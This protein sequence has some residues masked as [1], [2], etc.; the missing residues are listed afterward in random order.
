MAATPEIE[1]SNGAQ[2]MEHRNFQHS[3]STMGDADIKNEILGEKIQGP[4]Y[5]QNPD[6]S[7]DLSE[8][9][10]K[11]VFDV[12]AI[13]PVLS[14][15]MQL[16]NKAIDEIGMTSFQWKM[17]FLNGFGYAV[18]SV[19]PSRRVTTKCVSYVKPI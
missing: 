8:D 19:R 5:T 6:I 14:R 18:D 12:E 1:S 11:D 17:F 2:E 10:I 13:D 3:S 7:D 4:V 15:K 9:S 16:V